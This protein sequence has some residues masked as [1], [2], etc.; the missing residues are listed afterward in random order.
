MS[1]TSVHLYSIP[2]DGGTA[3]KHVELPLSNVIGASSSSYV[4]KD[5]VG[6]D[7]EEI[8][9]QTDRFATGTNSRFMNMVLPP[10]TV[11]FSINLNPQYS[12]EETAESLRNM[13]YSMIAYNFRGEIELRFMDGSTHVASLTGSITKFESDITSSDPEV[14]ITI[15]CPEGALKGPD[16]VEA[17]II[18]AT[19][20]RLTWDDITTSPPRSTMPIGFRL[21]LTFTASVVAPFVFS[22][23]YGNFSIPFSINYAFKAGDVLSLSS[24]PGNRYVIRTRNGVDLA[25]TDLVTSDSRWTMMLPYTQSVLEF[26]DFV[27]GATMLY[28]TAAPTTE[29]VDGDYYIRTT[30]NYIYGPKA[31]GVW[32]AGTWLVNNVIFDDTTAFAQ[33]V[34]PTTQGVNGNYYLREAINSIH[35]PKAAGVWPAENPIVDHSF[36]FGTAAP[37]TEGVNGDYYIRTTTNYIYGPKA[38]DTW[39]SG[40]ALKAVPTVVIHTSPPTND[41]GADGNYYVDYY[42]G[43]LYGPKVGGVWPEWNEGGGIPRLLPDLWFGTTVPASDYASNIG[44]VDGD[45]YINETTDYIYG[46]KANGEWPTGS[47]ILNGNIIYGQYTPDGGYGV[48]GDYY[49]KR[50]INE[51]IH[52]D[53]TALLYGPKAGGV[54]P[55][56]NPV[57]PECTLIWGDGVPT[58]QGIDGNYYYDQTN[59][60]FYGPKTDNVWGTGRVMLNPSFSYGTAAPTTQGADGDYY[61]RT[62]TH[63]IWG[64]KSNGAWPAGLPIINPTIIYGTDPPTN[65]GTN[66]DYYVR[67]AANRIYGPKANNTWPAGVPLVSETVYYEEISNNTGYRNKGDWYVRPSTSYFYGPKGA[68]VWPPGISLLGSTS[69]I[70]Q[71]GHPFTVSSLE[72]QRSYW[73]I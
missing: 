9:R 68:T 51:T 48:D 7:A 2:D 63:H 67:V 58:S 4:V 5:V 1:I 45:Y 17:T 30:T 72:F 55:A 12:Q 32:P 6:L 39:P 36:V 31:N 43:K 49:I 64:P 37:T 11:A 24:V 34:A 65:Q 15:Y 47:P 21:E 73:G 56:G 29:G 35:G 19:G 18:S 69:A 16:Y 38:N 50:G 40:S 23:E 28:G 59:H 3:H 53:G 71:L 66:G 22:I 57:V 52:E 14:K 26:P 13:L 44:S 41:Q 70:L 8:L 62:S 46:P 42:T 60:L 25:L 61:V 10:R 20:N 54:W 33:S 27:S